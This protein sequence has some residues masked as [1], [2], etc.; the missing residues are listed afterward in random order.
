DLFDPQ[1]PPITKETNLIDSI[2][3]QLSAKIVRPCDEKR[4]S[5]IERKILPEPLSTS[6]QLDL[7]APELDVSRLHLRIRG[8]EFF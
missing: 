5:R 7:P 6:Q 1:L 3:N 8:L 4:L 2:L